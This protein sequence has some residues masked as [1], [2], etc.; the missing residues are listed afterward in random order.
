MR[1][2]TRVVATGLAIGLV[3]AVGL[4]R[5]L[6]AVFRAWPRDTGSRAGAIAVVGPD[7]VGARRL[8]PAAVVAVT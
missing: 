5:L 1:F 7:A 4:S 3:G 2:G 8:S 6:G